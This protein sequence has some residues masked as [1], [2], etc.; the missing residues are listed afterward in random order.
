MVNHGSTGLIALLMALAL[1]SWASEPAVAAVHIEGQV[2]AGGGPVAHSAV[3]L[4][5][6]SSDA[7]AQIAQAET[8]AD[9]RFVIASEQSPHNDGSLYLVAV[10]GQPAIAKV[11][12]NNPALTML[13]VLGNRPPAKVTINEMTTIASVWTNAQFLDGA[14]I[15]G[16]ALG[17][18]I[19]AGN[20]PN[21]VDLATGG[22]GG[23]IQDAIN[24]TQTPTMAIFATLSNVMAGCA[25][26]LK[27]DACSS[28]FAAATGPDGKVPTNTLAAAQSIA[29][30]L[31]YKPDRLFAL[32]D[33]FYPVPKGKTLRPTP[34]LPY[35]RV[36]PS[37]WILP[38]KFTG[39]GLSGPG[40]IMF[41]REGNAWTG[42]N[43]IVGEQALGPC[44]ME[45]WP[46]SRR[47]AARFRR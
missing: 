7:P 19:A 6:A 21:F 32:L 18:R 30:A 39:G 29:R 40:K 36:A 28:F 13:A 14:G 15:K 46:S 41:D 8:R 42:V 44:G 20:V 4:W 26:Q 17:L 38:L 3:T 45:T 11:P 1:L 24:S 47:M 10:G 5:A 12:G 23:P 9:G 22:Y 33:D 27:A 35:L 31:A 43:F 25:T 34:F 37:A 2:E 16:Y